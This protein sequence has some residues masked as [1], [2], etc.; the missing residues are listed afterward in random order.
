[1]DRVRMKRIKTTKPV[2]LIKERII[3]GD[4]RYVT[5]IIF[6]ETVLSVYFEEINIHIKSGQRPP[7]F[8]TSKGAG[9][10]MLTSWRVK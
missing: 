10:T 9:Y 8:L 7:D 2:I 1:M 6:L 3:I 4:D 5:R